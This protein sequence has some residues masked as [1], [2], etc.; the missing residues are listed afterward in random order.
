MT[1]FV[2]RSKNVRADQKMIE[3]HMLA[4]FAVADKCF[5]ATTISD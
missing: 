3:K 2:S 4:E 5:I 1:C